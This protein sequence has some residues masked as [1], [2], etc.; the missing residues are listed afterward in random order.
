MDTP[1]ISIILATYNGSRFLPEAISSVLDQDYS[2]LELIVIDD[3]SVDT[4]VW[5]IIQDFVSKDSRVRSVRNERNMERS[6]SKNRWAELAKGEY[7]A[8]IDDDDMWD[9]AKLRRQVKIFDDASVGIVGTFAQYI[10]E[11]GKHISHTVHLKTSKQDIHDSIL[12][13]NQFIQSSVILRKDIFF[14][15]WG[16][17]SFNLCEDYDCWCRVLQLTS[18]ANI[19]ESLIKYRI[20]T[21]STTTKHLYRMKWITLILVWRYKKYFPHWF[22]AILFR[23]VT[24]PFNISFLLKLW[25]IVF[26]K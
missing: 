13:S 9:P 4:R 15:A 23:I 1:L 25:N 6:W 22:S 26:H 11:E 16:F 24:F 7:I 20:R 5:E 14:R 12:F 8:F 19:P 3:A 18:W 2:N 10:D 21:S 17:P